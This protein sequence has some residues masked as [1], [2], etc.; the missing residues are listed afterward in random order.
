MTTWKSVERRIA[1]LLGGVRVP[2]SGRQRGDSPDIAHDV[3]SIEVKHRETWPDWLHDAMNQAE[4]S[5]KDG[6][7][8]LVILHQKSQ[9][10]DQSYAIMRLCDT[11]SMQARIKA[12]ED[13]LEVKYAQE[14][15]KD[16]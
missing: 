8:P 12:L 1:A 9:K 7:I 2:V 15:G 11:I 14:A 10:F 3:F 16:Y 6:Q 5:Q 13:K 4:E